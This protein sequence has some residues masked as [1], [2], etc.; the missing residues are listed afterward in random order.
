[1]LYLYLPVP[2]AKAGILCSSVSSDAWCIERM[3]TFIELILSFKKFL[4][5]NL[6]FFWYFLQK[7]SV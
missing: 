5:V 6:N 3:Q 4:P 2:P 7:F 1:M